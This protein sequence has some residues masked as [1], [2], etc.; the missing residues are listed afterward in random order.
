MS[1]MECTRTGSGRVRCE[2]HDSWSTQD[3]AWIKIE[4][5]MFP[6]RYKSFIISRKEFLCRKVLLDA[7]MEHSDVLEELL[8]ELV[9]EKR[10]ELIGCMIVAVEFDVRWQGLIIC[11]THKSFPPVG[12]YDTPIMEHLDQEQCSTSE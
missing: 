10:P 4:P 3:M 7:V 5:L 9:L 11:V 1:D 2:K 12:L 6:T 8:L